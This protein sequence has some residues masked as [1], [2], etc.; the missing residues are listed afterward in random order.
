MSDPLLS[1]DDVR[2]GLEALVDE[3]VERGAST[4]IRVVGGAAVMIQA[5]REALSRDI[6]ALYPP[7]V[8]IDEAIRSVAMSKHWPN[9]WLNDAVK[10]F[11]SNYD[12]DKDWELH[13]TRAGVTVSVASCK[14]LLA[15]KLLAARPRD[16]ED[17]LLLIRACGITER[18]DAVDV[19][20]DYYPTESLKPRAL[21]IL[22]DVL[23]N[24]DGTTGTQ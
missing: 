3:L 18:Q 10:M 9:T 12:D 7:S 24:D 13:I 11:A 6:D 22:D 2:R 20:D 5:G 19:F 21:R 4:H 17:I 8:S 16:V 15:M 1:P 23:S 14:L